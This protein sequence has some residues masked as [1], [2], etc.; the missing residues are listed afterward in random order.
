M[1]FTS[2]AVFT[3]VAHFFVLLMNEWKKRKRAK[4]E[5]VKPVNQAPAGK[6][7]LKL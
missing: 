1:F 3:A 4:L 5:A 2:R 6:R 7:V